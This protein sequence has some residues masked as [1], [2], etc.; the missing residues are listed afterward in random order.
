M[1]PIMSKLKGGKNVF[2]YTIHAKTDSLSSCSPQPSPSSLP[3]FQW[4]SWSSQLYC[5]HC[6]SLCMFQFWRV[7]IED[8]MTKDSKLNG[9]N[10]RN[11]MLTTVHCLR[12]IWY[13][14]RFGS[15]F[16]SRLQVIGCHFLSLFLCI[17]NDNGRDRTRDLSNARIVR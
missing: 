14:R 13:A 6:K 1:P 7:S 16:Y 15:C 12:H 10:Y 3:L 8:G 11:T 2:S 5:G 9:S 17:I 4:R